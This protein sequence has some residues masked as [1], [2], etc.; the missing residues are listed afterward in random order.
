MKRKNIILYRVFSASAILVLA[1]AG[2]SK[3]G[4]N[5][6]GSA[7]ASAKPSDLAAAKKVFAA[8]CTTCH[9]TKGLGDGPGA[10]ALKPKPRAFGDAA[11]Q[12]SVDDEHIK[13]TIV[14]GGVAVGKSPIMP[15]NPDLKGK[16]AVLN[17]LVQVIRNFKK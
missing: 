4:G 3:A 10:K 5:T 2:C 11:W 17:G 6:G 14:A 12:A 9:G 15:G 7:Q 8:R 13:K 16:E 1:L